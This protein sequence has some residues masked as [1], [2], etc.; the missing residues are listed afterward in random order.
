MPGLR[1]PTPES[2]KAFSLLEITSSPGERRVFSRSV[3]RV[4]ETSADDT[5]RQPAPPFLHTHTNPPGGPPQTHT[6]A[7]GEMN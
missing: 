2:G 3:A 6:T 1:R 4:V 7:S 5:D